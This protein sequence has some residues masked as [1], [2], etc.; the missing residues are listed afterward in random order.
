MTG[1]DP[2][3]LRVVAT[4]PQAQVAAIQAGGKARIEVP[5][6]GRWVDVRAMTIVPTADPRTHTTRIRL[7]L[8]TEVRGVYPGVYARVHF[9]V[10]KAPRLLVPRAAVLKRSEVT[11]V[12]VVDGQYRAH[13]RQIRL[14]SA[15]DEVSVEVLAGLKPGE[16]VALEP[17][18][19]GMA[20]PGA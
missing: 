14:G 3:T 2:S 7:D 19:A 15:G 8:P 5:S 10:G 17:V 18:K 20:A 12:Y 1:F 9:V 4:V 16:R 6:L 11:A 13:L